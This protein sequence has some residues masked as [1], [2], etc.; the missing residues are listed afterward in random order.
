MRIDCHAHVIVPDV[1]RDA[2]PGEAWRPRV[3]REDGAQVV[4]LDGRPIRSAVGEFVGGLASS[5]RTTALAQKA[6]QLTVPGVADT[7]QGTELFDLSLVDPDNRRPVDYDARRSLL[8]LEGVPGVDDAGGAKLHVV[9]RLLRLRREHT[10]LFLADSSYTPLDAGERAVAYVRGG[11]VVTVAPTR[12]L[13]VERSGWGEDAVELPEGRW[14][15]VL[16]GAEQAGGRVRLA[17]LVSGFPVAVLLR[18]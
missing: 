3:W 7:Y 1:L 4:E 10:E 9:S 8:A 6:V 14:T 2:A 15:D 13:Q 17:D 18:E 12:A 5:W 16:T 11:R